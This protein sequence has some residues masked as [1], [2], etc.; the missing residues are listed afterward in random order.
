MTSPNLVSQDPADDQMLIASA[1]KNDQVAWARLVEMYSPVLRGAI[2]AH[3]GLN[4]TDEA[5]QNTW[6]RVWNSLKRYDSKVAPFVAFCRW[7]ARNA[8]I[9]ILR[10][11]RRRRH[12][13]VAEDLVGRSG[14]ESD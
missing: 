1:L 8:A 12:E 9:D 7:H 14:L 4:D 13:V 5:L 6:I 11:N 2:R 3:L 10:R